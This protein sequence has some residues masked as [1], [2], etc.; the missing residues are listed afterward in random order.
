MS[1]TPEGIGGKKWS[2]YVDSTGQLL[3]MEGNKTIASIVDANFKHLLVAAPQLWTE[4]NELLVATKAAM[5]ANEALPAAVE[6]LSNVVAK[7]VNKDDW[8]KVSQA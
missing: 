4:A 7:A 5:P 3:L 2:L 8:R 1:V 6:R